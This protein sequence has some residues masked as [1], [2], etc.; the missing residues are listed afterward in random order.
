M[1]TSQINGAQQ[2]LIQQLQAAL[3]TPAP[4]GD[5]TYERP[6]GQPPQAPGERSFI[7]PPGAPVVVPPQQPQFVQPQQPQAPVVQQPQVP[8]APAPQ[9]P[10]TQLT[11]QNAPQATNTAEA[12]PQ[13]VA[14][15]DVAAIVDTAIYNVPQADGT[16]AA[17]TGLEMR[18]SIMRQR[19]YTQKTQ[20][21]AQRERELSSVQTEHQQLT[22][23]KGNV[24]ADLQNPRK[25]YEHILATF[26]PQ[27]V[28]EA[29]AMV[30]GQQPQAPATAAPQGQDQIATLADA[31]Q[32]AFQN[33]QRIAA[34]QQQ[35]SQEMQ[36][37]R[38]ELVTVEKRARTHA[39]NDM[40]TAQARTEI[41]AVVPQIIEALPIL[42]TIPRYQD[43]LRFNVQSK[44]RTTS[45]AEVI[46]AYKAEAQLMA[47]E[48]TQRYTEHSKALL[49]QNPA[50]FTP[51]PLV[52]NGL[53]TTGPATVIAGQSPEPTVFVGADGKVDKAAWSKG[54]MGFLQSRIGQ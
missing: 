28:Q 49:L 2:G 44:Y 51:A 53:Q 19:D 4:P 46:T 1:D 3:A 54:V 24:Q 29:Y 32:F 39:V 38:G 34:L 45:A 13:Q 14:N 7:T 27:F 25:V 12:S 42:K 37:L 26:G 15:T 18:Q 20:Q 16:T 52:Q 6:T 35:H 11:P 22:S 21:V 33:E 47:T 8:Q 40:E 5:V 23:W 31:R 30:T 10:L 43:L 17:M 48:Q 9:N 50:A 36:A 41:N